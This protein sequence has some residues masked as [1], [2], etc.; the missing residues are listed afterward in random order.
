MAKSPKQRILNVLPEK[1][2]VDVV[3]ERLQVIRAHDGHRRLSRVLTFRWMGELYDVE[4]DFK[5]DYSSYPRA[6]IL[7]GV[8]VVLAWAFGSLN[9]LWYWL[10]P[11]FWPS[12]QK[13]DYAGI[14]HD[15]CWRDSDWKMSL[16]RG[17]NF[18]FCAALTGE[19]WHNRA[20][21]PQAAAGWLILNVVAAFKTTV[22]KLTRSP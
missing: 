8:P 11:F 1:Y 17:N 13:T 10:I 19:N 7:W 15:K 22:R 6:L 4:E 18:W 5:T 21:L 12:W 20:T 3:G 2:R 9:F 14:G 16:F